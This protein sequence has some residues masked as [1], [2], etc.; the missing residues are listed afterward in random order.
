MEIQGTRLIKLV[1]N[2]QTNKKE[3]NYNYNYDLTTI[4]DLH[5]DLRVMHSFVLYVA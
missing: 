3:W 4:Y 1:I 5:I 2:K